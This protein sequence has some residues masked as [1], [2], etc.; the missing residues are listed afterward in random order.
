[1]SLRMSPKQFSVTM[2]SNCHGSA[3]MC[4]AQASIAMWRAGTSGWAARASRQQRCHSAPAC[5]I[6]CHLSASTTLDRAAEKA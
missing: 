4:R 2:T 3:I 6:A 5:G 1:M